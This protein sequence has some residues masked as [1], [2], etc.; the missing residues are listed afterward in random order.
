MKKIILTLLTILPFFIFAQTEGVIQFKET[1]ALNI[2]LPEGM[3]EFASQIPSSQSNN[4]TLTFNEGAAIYE[5][6]KNNT[7]A[8]EVT[9]GSEDGGMM[10]NMKFDMPENKTFTNIAEGTMVNK[11]DF[12]GKKFLIQGKVEK[13][14]WKLTGEQ[15]TILGYV[16]QKATYKKDSTHNL[17]AW[18]T[19]QIPVATG[20]GS[21]SGL[22]GMILKLDR[23]DGQMVTEATAI[24]LQKIEKGTIKPPKKGKKV[25][26]EEFEKIQEE[27]LKEMEAEFGASGSGGTRIIIQN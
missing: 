18:F 1:I 20:P 3:E 26:K 9:M 10:F 6:A 25:S 11:Q 15:E 27:K 21:V 4:M 2:E 22:P 12:M 19:P 14:K 16:C 5:Q 13:Y 17:I 7:D 23:N 8:E 24:E